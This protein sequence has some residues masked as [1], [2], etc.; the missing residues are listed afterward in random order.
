MKGTTRLP[1]LISLVAVT[2][3]RHVMRGRNYLR[4]FFIIGIAT[5]AIPTLAFGFFTSFEFED[6][7]GEFPVGDAPDSAT[8]TGG[9]ARGFPGGFS[10]SHT[11]INAWVVETGNTGTITFP[12]SANQVRFFLKDE[13][14]SVASTV[15]LLDTNNQTIAT[16]IGTPDWT[17]VIHLGHAPP[18]GGD[19][20]AV[21]SIQVINNSTVSGQTA[22]DTFTSAPSGEGLMD[23]I[24]KPIETGKIHVTLKTVATGLT[25]PN[26]GTFAPGVPRSPLFVTDQPGFLWAIDLGTGAKL[27]ILDVSDRLVPLGAFGD[28]DE[29]GLLG[30]AFHPNYA[31]NGLLYTYTSEPVAGDAD[32]TTMPPGV[33]ADH[34]S[35]ILEWQVLPDPLDPQSVV[36][37][38]SV[39]E[40]LRID[41]PQF[42]NNGGAVNFGPDGRLYISLGDGGGAD[43]QDGQDFLGNPMVGHGFGNGQNPG[44]PLGTVLRI[45]PQ[46]SN[47][48]NGNYGIPPDNPFVGEGGLI[49]EIFAYGF[50]NP[51]R[52]SFDPLRG[53]LYLADRGQNDIEEVNI[54]VSGG[55]YGWNFKE[56]SFPFDPNGTADGFVTDR[57]LSG[58][59]LDFIDPI[60]EYDHD[61]GMAIV[62]GFV[63]H[64]SSRALQDHYVFADRSQDFFANN[65]RL[66]YLT[67]PDGIREFAMDRPLDI[68]VMGMGQ[69]A[70]GEL[71]VLGN[72]T[73][74]PFPDP[75]QG[76]TGVVLKL[77]PPQPDS[78]DLD[79][80]GNDDIVWRNTNSGEVATWLMAGLTIKQV[81]VLGG[82]PTDWAIEGVGDVDGDGQADIVWRNTSNGNVAIWLMNGLT[83]KQVG[84]PGSV[85]L[86]WRIE[87]VGDVDGDGNADIVWRDTS[88]GTVAIWLMN[89]LTIKQVGVPGNVPVS[90]TIDGVGDV[91]GD[92]QADIVWRDNITGAVAIWLMNGLTIKQVGVPGN[93]PLSWTLEGVGDTNGDGKVDLIWRDNTSGA[94]AIW[95]MNGLTIQQVG[96]PGS[97]GTDWEIQ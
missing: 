6:L 32:F 71:Y 52:F 77:V 79:G 42:N 83:I 37:P 49:E 47:S 22:V 9:E 82:S 34:Q 65:G 63:Y 80:D 66:F 45:D 11:G 13:D 33:P 16:F 59:P 55:N 10:P 87:G 95:Q 46:G 1:R 35:V 72:T 51:Y 28:Y 8:F 24:P 39:R 31:G 74:T 12:T 73:G 91:D 29:R 69:D 84:V 27:A 4:L 18:T 81:G 43:D 53:Q 7:S 61:E 94:V 14:S 23:P 19:G 57:D 56:G 50:R 62:G 93:V 92:G 15:R 30:V 85:S 20:T 44:N 40:L 58:L 90:W 96:V 21:A 2:V 36:D 78:H 60:A 25:A 68:V 17:E 64:G 67:M 3:Y 26:W 5:I 70:H 89:G 97:V 41:E 75:V 88:N 54:V 48:A 38:A 76:P 86:S